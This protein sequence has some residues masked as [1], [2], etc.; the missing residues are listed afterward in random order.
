MPIPFV[1]TASVI[2]LS[3]ERRIKR[4]PDYTNLQ[5]PEIRGPR[6]CKA[7]KGGEA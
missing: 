4:L 2:S 5:L 7:R 1:A 6:I 3:S